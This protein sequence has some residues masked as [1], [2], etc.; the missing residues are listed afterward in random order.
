MILGNSKF[1]II[2]SFFDAF[3]ITFFENDYTCVLNVA[4]SGKISTYVI[5]S[6]NVSSEFTIT[7]ITSWFFY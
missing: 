5:L 6:I 3:K 7:F 1:A 2:S 4:I